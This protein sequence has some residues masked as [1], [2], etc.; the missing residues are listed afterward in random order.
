MKVGEYTVEF[1]ELKLPELSE[2]E[3]TILKQFG[4][5]AKEK[6]YFN[7]EAYRKVAEKN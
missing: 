2:T 7:S 3:Q 1:E 5:W 6:D 4:D